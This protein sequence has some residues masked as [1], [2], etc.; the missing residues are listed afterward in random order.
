MVGTE[1]PNAQNA[2]KHPAYIYGF[3]IKDTLK[4]QVAFRLTLKLE[5]CRLDWT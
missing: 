4:S 1:N 3:D 5:V 2:S